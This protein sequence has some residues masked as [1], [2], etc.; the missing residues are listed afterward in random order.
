M[1]APDIT[2]RDAVFWLGMAGL[3]GCAST[4]L[5]K[6][7]PHR[8]IRIASTPSGRERAIAAAVLREA[9]AIRGRRSA[10]ALIEDFALA[11]MGRRHAA[12]MAERGFFGHV[13]PGG[14]NLLDRTPRD[15]LVNIANGGIAENLWEFGSN[16][17]LFPQD[18][19][20]RAIEAWLESPGHRKTLLAD[21]YEFAGVG[22]VETHRRL[23]VAMIFADAV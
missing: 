20:D 13:T 6:P 18:Y 2:R 8:V 7:A 23:L 9:S 1:Q 17:R 4:P 11:G 22:V 3:T 5:S 14:R 10:P 15:V 21:R 16:L 12:D 19:A